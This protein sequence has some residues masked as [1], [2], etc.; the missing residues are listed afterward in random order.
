[1]I[2][3]ASINR[4]ALACLP[5]LVQG[6]IPGGAYE[7]D[8]YV[9]RNPKRN[10]L[11]PGSFKINVRTGK[12]GDFAAQVG[13]GDPISLWAFLD[14]VKQ[15]EAAKRLAQRLGIDAGRSGET[16]RPIVPVPADAP[17][18]DAWRHPKHGRPIAGWEYRSADGALIGYIVRLQY[19][20]GRGRPTKDYLP[21]CFCD[22]TFKCISS[23]LI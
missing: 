22:V 14:D 12:W 23:N 17:S 19:M 21:L 16:K 4:A 15:G 18:A 8:E 5:E 13:G 11:S 3:F 7:G 10:D 6:W 2:D 20:D 9:V 1:V